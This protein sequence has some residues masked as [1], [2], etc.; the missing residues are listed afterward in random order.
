MSVAVASAAA[1][2]TPAA[3]AAT[4]ATTAAAVAAATTAAAITS[5]A[6]TTAAAAAIAAAAATVAA[7]AVAAATTVATATPATTEAAAAAAA[8]VTAA[9]LSYSNVCIDGLVCWDARLACKYGTCKSN[10]EH[11]RMAAQCVGAVKEPIPEPVHSGGRC[12]HCSHDGHRDQRDKMLGDAH[13]GRGAAGAGHIDGLGAAIVTALDIELDL[14]SLT[15]AAV[16]VG[17]DAGLQVETL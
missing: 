8:T 2:I 7:A 13:Q 6:A 5:A 4:A 3:A 9:L 11:I 17:L 12:K 16:A 1:A 14:L 10:G 15:Q